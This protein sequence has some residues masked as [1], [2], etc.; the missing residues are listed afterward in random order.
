M[1][2]VTFVPGLELSEGF[3]G[4]AVAPILASAF[5]R[6]RYT[7]AL[8]GPGSEVLGFDTP[9][10]MDHHWGPRVM[11]FVDPLELDA[12]KPAIQAALGRQLPATYLGFSTHF[13][14]PDP[15]DHGVQHRE[16]HRGGPINH[17]VEVDTLD[18]FFRSY[19]GL[20]IADAMEP[21]DWLSIPSQKLRS[22]VAGGV[23]RDD[24][25]LAELRAR[26]AWYPRDVEL[27]VCGC[28]WARI[29]QEDH[30]MGRAADV[31]D[32]LGASLIAGR[33]ARD[34]MR[35]VFLLQREY[36]P[37]PKWFGTAF[38]RLAGVEELLAQ[39]QAA[40]WATRHSDRE[41]A[42]SAACETVARMQ[43]ARGMPMC[44]DLRVRGFHGRPFRVIGAGDIADACFAAI[45]DPGVAALAGARPIGSVDVLS[46]NTD[47]LEDASLRPLLRTLYGE[48]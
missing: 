7:A 31:G 21:A 12:R 18:A 34:L 33:L 30:L 27:Y 37:Y 47:L 44:P 4:E 20:A 14:T 16:E 6:L 42:L 2:E 45:S 15:R 38:A 39:L 46:D 36:A 1:T 25:G 22:M 19:L 32:E 23:F 40:V 9:M 11:L 26:L 35:I 10:S 3:Y 29:A 8:I 17:R 13:T 28:L 41:D 48:A 24:L 5:P 43:R